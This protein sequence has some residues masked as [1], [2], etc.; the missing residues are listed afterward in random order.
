MGCVEEKGMGQRWRND[1]AGDTGRR[2]HHQNLGA[3]SRVLIADGKLRSEHGRSWPKVAPG[4]GADLR[5]K[6]LFPTLLGLRPLFVLMAYFC[7]LASE[8]WTGL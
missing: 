1:G 4:A 7:P 5:A 2:C 8:A 3:E 6:A